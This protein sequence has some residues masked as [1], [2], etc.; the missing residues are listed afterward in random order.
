MSRKEFPEMFIPTIAYKRNGG[1]S[2]KVTYRT[3]TTSRPEPTMQIDIQPSLSWI[4][5]SRTMPSNLL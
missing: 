3:T 1:I 5:T 4:S 2:I